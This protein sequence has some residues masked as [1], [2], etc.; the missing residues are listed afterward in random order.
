M[1]CTPGRSK[2]VV[3]ALAVVTIIVEAIKHITEK[4]ISLR[5]SLVFLSVDQVVFYVV[6][7]VTI[8]V[9]N[10]TVVCAVRRASNCSDGECFGYLLCLVWN[11]ISRKIESYYYYFATF[12]VQTFTV[13]PTAY[14]FATNLFILTLSISCST[15]TRRAA[16]ESVSYTHLTLPTIYSV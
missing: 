1:Y 13:T 3:V 15:N 7:P 12:I 4:F 14:Y 8:L 9:I 5:T 2:K 10:V 6:L 11:N 16:L